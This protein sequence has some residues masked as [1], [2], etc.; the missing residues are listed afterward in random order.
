MTV[1]VTRDV[2][3]RYRGFLSSVMA[4]IAP[5]TYVSVDL[6]SGARDRVW[7]VL[8]DWWDA[9]PGSSVVMVYAARDASGGL[10]VRAL[11]SPPVTFADLDGV[12]VVVR[13]P[14]VGGD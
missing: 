12:R 3:M 11:G 4:E 1:V 8:A 14:A 6:S 13:Q 2:A 5:G 7:D 9:A 10:A